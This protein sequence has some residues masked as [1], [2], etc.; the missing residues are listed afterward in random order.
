MAASLKENIY[1]KKEFDEDIRQ[2]WLIY[3]NSY[4][5]YNCL[6]EIR[7]YERT[8]FSDA[9]FLF[10]IKY[11]SWYVLIIELCKVFQHDNK[12]QHF[13]VYGLLNKLRDNYKNLEF[14]LLIPLSDIHKYISDFNS[15]EI[16]EIRKKLVTLRNKFY[17]HFDRQNQKFIEEIN[18]TLN[19]IE[20]LL[21]LLHDFINNI[22]LKVFNSH[23]EFKED[24]FVDILNVLRNTENCNR[25]DH[26]EIIR[27]FNEETKKN[28][29]LIK[30]CRQQYRI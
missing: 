30:A 7:E 17:A 6:K 5:Y 16:I 14:N 9:R 15:S 24:I 2:I 23:V 10:F 29:I 18:I 19:E 1:L 26:E 3:T 25:R 8:E 21:N 28:K 22:R 27:K 20:Y 4:E 13:N 11:T 12:S